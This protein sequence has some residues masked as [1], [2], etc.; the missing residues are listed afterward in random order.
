MKRILTFL[1]ILNGLCVS[2]QNNHTDDKGRKQG[3]WVKKYEN[4]K[5]RYTG[6][7]KD[8]VPVG[9][10]TY[11]FIREGGIMSEIQY[12]S[13]TGIGYAKLY[14]KS[15]TLQAEGI[16]NAQEKDSTWTYYAR[17]GLLTQREDYSKG[18]LN[19]IQLTYWE[20]GTVSQRIEFKEGLEDGNWIRKWEDGTLRT[21]GLYKAGQLE[22]ECKFYEEEGKIIAKGEYHNGKKHGSWYY[23]EENKLTLKE[24]YRYGSLESE[25]LYN[26]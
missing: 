13:L 10:F 21:K 12:R 6:I 20:N 14:H 23:F 8:D 18:I 25:T 15:G 11:Y 24:L 9:T 5:I 26:E 16:Y 17:T 2:A 7:F 22:G 19:G 4:G 3:K 1:L